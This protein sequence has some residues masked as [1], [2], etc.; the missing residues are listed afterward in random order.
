MT[1]HHQRHL[2]EYELRRAAERFGEIRMVRP[3]R[4]PE[5]VVRL[6]MITLSQDRTNEAN[7]QKI[8]E[9]F[10]SRGAVLFVDRMDGQ[11]FMGGTLELRF[12]WDELDS[13]L[14]PPP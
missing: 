6:A 8:V 10:D 2:D 14:P 13:H 12:M 9:F 5:C 4:G 3:C 7:S 11:A 1:L